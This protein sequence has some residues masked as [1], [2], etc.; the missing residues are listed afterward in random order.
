MKLKSSLLV[1][2]LAAFAVLAAFAPSHAEIVDLSG[3]FSLENGLDVRL[4]PDTGTPMVAV[5]AL[6]RTGYASEGASRSG[7]SHL[8]EHLVFAGTSKRSKN[9]IQREVEGLG[10]YVNGF[11]RDDYT[12]YLIVGHSDHLGQLLDVLCPVPMLGQPRGPTGDHPLGS[13]V[14]LRDLAHLVSGDATLLD[15]PFEAVFG[16]PAAELFEALAVLVDEVP[17]EHGSRPQVV[18][19]EE[20]LHDALEQHS[21]SGYEVDALLGDV[22]VHVE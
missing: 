7:F 1:A 6:V 12:A 5:M 9:Q 19:G 17:V 4:M 13:G 18:E 20:L 14:D 22:V 16:E 21:F 8:L 10:G 2:A 15:Q 3:T 11:T